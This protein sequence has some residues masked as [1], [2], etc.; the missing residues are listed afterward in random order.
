MSAAWSPWLA[1]KKQIKE[2]VYFRPP[3]PSAEGAPPPPHAYDIQM[4]PG[5]C[6]T[7]F[8]CLTIVLFPDSPAPETDIKVQSE[9]DEMVHL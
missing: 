6:Y 4:S 7:Y 2:G 1:T 5:H 3:A 9:L 8:I